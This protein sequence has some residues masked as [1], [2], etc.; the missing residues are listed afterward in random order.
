VRTISNP[1]PPPITGIPE[2]PPSGGGGASVFDSP[3]ALSINAARMAH[4][5]SLG[6]P[7][8]GKTVLDLGSGVGH[9]A[10]SLLELGCQVTCV[11]GRPQNIAILRSRH[12][13]IAAH[14]ANVETDSLAAFGRFD[15]VFCYGLLYHLEN[16][17]AGLR[18]MAQACKDLLV[19]ETV[20]TDH[21]EP[22]LRLLDEP[23]E[24]WNQAL[25]P[26]G[27]RPSPAFVALALTRAGF[28]CVYAPNEPPHH[29]D[30]RFDWR[31]N[32]EFSRDGH[33]LRSIFIAS[34]RPL[35]N[36]ALSLL[37]EG[38]GVSPPQ[39][40]P[41]PPAKRIW[42]DVGAH[43]GEKTFAAAQADPALRVYAFEPNLAVAAQKMGALPNFIMLPVAVAE[44]DG[45][46]EFHLNSFDAASSLLPMDPR[47]LEQWIGGEQL[48]V[49]ARFAVPAL[50]LD[51]F[52]ERAG[53]R[54]VEFLKIDAQGADL[55]VLRSAGE[56]LRDIQKISLEV[57]ITP[58]PL[59]EGGS[60]KEAV[61]QHMQRAGFHLIT[62]ERQSHDQEENLTF[63]RQP[64]ASAAE[65]LAEAQAAAFLRPLAPYPGWNFGADW[66]NPDP[67]YVHRRRLWEYFQE[68]KLESSFP[69]PW[70]DGLRLNL[71]LGNDLSRQ[72]FIAGCSEPN[73]FAFLD[74]ILAPGMVFVDAGANDGIYSLF[75][76]RRVGPEGKVWSFEPSARE[77]G[78]LEQNLALNGLQ[79]VRPF[80]VALAERNG[81][82]ELI[83]ADYGH[84]GQNTLGAFVHQ[85]IDQKG[86]ERIT[87]RKLDDLVQEERLARI[88]IL[89][90]DVEGA[91]HR[92]L[93][94]ARDVLAKLRPV[95]LCEVL[96]PALQKQ[97]S[98]RAELIHFLTGA[99]YRIYV[100]EERTG[101]PAALQEDRFSD[102]IIALPV[103][104][105][106]IARLETAGSEAAP[107]SNE[108]N[109]LAFAL[110]ENRPL[111]RF[112]PARA[113][114]NQR[115]TLAG[116]RDRLLA[117]SRA[118]NHMS[119]LWPYQWAQL[120][121]V[122]LDYQPDVVLELGRG[123]GNSTCAFTEASN[124]NQGRTR[125]LS[126]CLSDDW[127]RQTLPQ[128][129]PIVPKDWFAPL[130]ALRANILEFDYEMALSGA[131]RV[132]IF[133]DAHGFEIAE[134]V[135]GEILPVVAGKEHLVLMHDL[136]D[137]RYCSEEQLE[138]GGHGLW[139][140]NDWSGPRLKLGIIDSA[141]EQSIAAL[142]FTTR[143]HL[144]LDSADHSFH[145]NLSPSQQAEMLEILGGLFET[146]GHWFY[147]SL[148]EVP[149]P[150]K[151]PHFTRPKA[152]LR[153]G[154]ARS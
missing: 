78:R 151:F 97:N 144:S 24:T 60:L 63:E 68:R 55:A 79:N 94:G 137:T 37:M 19:L 117:L 45:A 29:P 145:T 130:Q 80:P 76:A 52:L 154:A 56:R 22:I 36:P 69:F 4:L 59:Y 47:G 124:L 74:R 34:R 26:L 133:W 112:S 58:V 129:K 107:P 13:G 48:K 72:L 86:V 33:L 21:S 134:C 119:D 135:L 70:Y 62:A 106:W 54:Q 149:A 140:R 122:V 127:D 20:I 126:L 42:L 98:S 28:A 138:Y 105:D 143:N 65:A 23:P 77:F 6:L 84:E 123:K 38:P 81:Q 99:G 35:Q 104:S 41:A 131:E 61:L 142:D 14:V 128:I 114:W 152:F 88:D 92:V 57:Q 3:D 103:E 91:E 9:L 96:D 89:K 93:L 132:V 44:Q 2:T 1:G 49:E 16:P 30:F 146:Q 10:K 110:K 5:A 46:V 115:Q 118:V 150:Y 95:I 51:T 121:S 64:W 113:Y 136:S 153:S 148:N 85:G 71:Y 109:A 73:E 8:A 102:N 90:L 31:G 147:F 111:Y 100:F 32:L 53:I 7:L 67:S 43:L 15:I 27:N 18:N 12:P 116:A 139:K 17:V 87:V 125:V 40:F 66:D 120:M 141:V 83:V 101:Q 50:R 39:S 11:D 108:A 75:A 25:G 82:E